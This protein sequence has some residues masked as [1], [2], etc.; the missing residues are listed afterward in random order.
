MNTTNYLSV[1][2][3]T[4]EEKLK[5]YKKCL[6]EELAKMLIQANK[7]IEMFTKQPTII[8]PTI[9]FWQVGVPEYKPDWTYPIQ[10]TITCSSTSVTN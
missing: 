3:M 8:Y 2:E 7:H 6:K 5:M 10:P 9:P 4:D 1:V